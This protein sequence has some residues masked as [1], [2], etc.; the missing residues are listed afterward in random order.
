MGESV[1]QLPKER[2]R[3]AAAEDTG[4]AVLVFVR[5]GLGHYGLDASMAEEIRRSVF[6]YENLG[7]V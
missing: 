2:I 6:W 3:V 7:P 1:A 4:F 5:T